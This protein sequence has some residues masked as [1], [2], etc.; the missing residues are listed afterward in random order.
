MTLRYPKIPHSTSFQMVPANSYHLK[1]DNSSMETC[2]NVL[3]IRQSNGKSYKTYTSHHIQSKVSFQFFKISILV[4]SSYIF[5]YNAYCILSPFLLSDPI[6]FCIE[7][8]YPMISCTHVNLDTDPSRRIHDPRSL[9]PPCISF[10]I[11]PFF[12]FITWF[13]LVNSNPC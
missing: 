2:T 6:L 5:Q 3:R 13:K 1:D 10:I 12:L 9:I 11:I 4:F 8:L 7:F